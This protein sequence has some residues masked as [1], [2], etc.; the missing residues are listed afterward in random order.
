MRKVDF[1]LTARQVRN[2][3]GGCSNMALW[4]WLQDDTMQFPRPLVINRRRLW[5][6]ADL[7]HFEEKQAAKQASA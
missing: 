3:Y 1:Y 4:R 5:K 6:I 7:E 2:R